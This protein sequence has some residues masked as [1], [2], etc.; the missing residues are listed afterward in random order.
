M[1]IPDHPSAFGRSAAPL[2]EV[3]DT[4]RAPLR[5]NERFF[6]AHPIEAVG[7][8]EVICDGLDRPTWLPR[9]S[10]IRVVPGAGGHR[11]RR[12]GA[13]AS[14][15]YED[16]HRK[17]INRGNVIIP[18]DC[19]IDG[20]AGYCEQILTIHKDVHGNA[21]PFFLP[22]WVSY[23]VRQRGGRIDPVRSIDKSKHARWRL[24]LVQKGIVPP[25]SRELIAE[26][27][28]RLRREVEQAES[29]GHVDKT[30]RD[31]H[32]RRRSDLLDM[33]TDAL[34]P[35]PTPEPPKKRSRAPRK[36]AA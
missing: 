5:P 35:G 14:S 12:N 3:D 26:T 13:K 24:S 28:K 27:L 8:W 10:M 16:A 9:V 17:L 29:A 19:G 7:S 4:A 15:I 32:V 1:P 33:W 11:Q 21:R 30:V 2:S 22:P 23:S 31:R 20:S 18:P 6:F 25:P 34:V 36:E